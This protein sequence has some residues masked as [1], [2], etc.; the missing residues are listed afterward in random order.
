MAEAKYLL[1]NYFDVNYPPDIYNIFF[2]AKQTRNHMHTLTCVFCILLFLFICMQ[3]CLKFVYYV[4]CL[5]RYSVFVTCACIHFIYA[6]DLQ[7]FLSSEL[8]L[9]SL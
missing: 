2:S 8:S 9:Q 3:D 5:A 6:K 1:L 4:F 7:Q